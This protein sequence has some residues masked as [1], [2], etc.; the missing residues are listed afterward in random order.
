MFIPQTG[1]NLHQIRVRGGRSVT[2]RKTHFPK[3]SQIPDLEAAAEAFANNIFEPE[4]FRLRCH[5]FSLDPLAYSLAL[6]PSDVA[7]PENWWDPFP[8]EALPDG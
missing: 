8:R 1:N 3:H 4:G 2:L 5:I 7:V 6:S